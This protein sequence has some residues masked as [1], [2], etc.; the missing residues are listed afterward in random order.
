MSKIRKL[1]EHGLT[2]STKN[3]LTTTLKYAKLLE[4]IF[5]GNYEYCSVSEEGTDSDVRWLAKG[6][7]V[8][9]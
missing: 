5:S 1:K 2:L 7:I 8:G 6:H 4:I 9:W 3:K